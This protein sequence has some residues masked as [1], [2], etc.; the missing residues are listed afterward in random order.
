MS[1]TSGLGHGVT[2]GSDRECHVGHDLP[3]LKQAFF[4]GIPYVEPPLGNLRL[5]PPIL[6]TSLAGVFN[7][8]T[9]GRACLQL[10][11]PESRPTQKSPLHGGGLV[12]GAASLDNGS[13]IVA[14]S[15][16]RGTPLIYVNFDYRLG[17]LGFPQ[18]TEATSQGALSLGL[19][20]QIAALEWLQLRIGVFGGDKDKPEQRFSSLGRQARPLLPRDIVNV[21]WQNFVGGVVSCSSTPT[22]NSTFDCLRTANS[23][24][25]FEGL[26]AAMVETT[27]FAPWN[28]TIDG[29]GGVIPDVLSVL[30]EQGTILVPPTVNSTEQVASF[31]TALFSPTTSAS[32]Q[33]VIADLLQVYPDIPAL[34]S[35]FN[36]G[37]EKF[38]LDSQYKRLAAIEPAHFSTVGDLAFHAPRRF[39]METAA[40]AGVKTFGYLF[41]QPQPES[42][43]AIRVFHGAEIPFVYSNPSDS[44]ASFMSLSEVMTEYWVSF[45]T[46]LIPTM[47]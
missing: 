15:V 23:S 1:D 4:G 36:T 38:G 10:P 24:E 40:N 27:S 45:A 25:N 29:A 17:P 12:H 18:G 31:L 20:D 19:R 41:T 9:F 3:L 11:N 42:P 28:P 7:A 34:G 5:R 37:N 33:D 47:V 22:S 44:S 16:A 35:P 21:D 6:K 39:W 46:S 8:T 32:E 43:S 14:R 2:N 30:A 26:T 13:E